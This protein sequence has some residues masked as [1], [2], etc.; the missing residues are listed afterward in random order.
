MSIRLVAIVLIALG[1]LTLAY[2]VLT[3]T[4]RETVID[5]GPIEVTTEKEK[6]VPLTPY[7]G[8]AALAIGFGLLVLRRK[9]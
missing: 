7:L 8:G 4:T 9:A 2:P 3:Y 6:R 1:A 5:V